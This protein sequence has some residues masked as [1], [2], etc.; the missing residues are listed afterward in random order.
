ML[1]LLDSKHCCKWRDAILHL[2]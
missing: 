1:G 2:L